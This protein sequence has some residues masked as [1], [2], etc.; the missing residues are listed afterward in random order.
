MIITMIQFDEEKQNKRLEDLKY[1]EEE[2]LVRILAGAK[3]NIPYID[4][5]TTTIENEA[6]RIVPE[7]TARAVEIAPFKL[8]GKNLH[9]A[10]RSPA[11]SELP[12]IMEDLKSQGYTPNLYMASHASLEK[13]WSRFGEISFASVSRAGGLD[14]SGEALLDIASKVHNINDVSKVV[15]DASADNKTHK[16]SHMLEIILG[17]AIAIKA[18]DI[19]IEPGEHEVQVRFRLDGVLQNILT[20]PPETYKL[21]NSRIK[22]ISGL[23]LVIKSI[24]QDGRFSIYESDGTEISMRVSIIPGA[25][26][27][28]IVMRILDPKSIQVK[29]EEIG[30]PKKLLAIMEAEIAKPN[31]LILITGPTG[32]GKTTTL[33]AFLRRIYSPEIKIITIEDPIEYHLAGITQTQVEKN[34]TFLE[35]LRSA[36]RQ[37]PDVIMIG[38]IRDSETAKIA[39]ES[40]LTG[41]LVFS[42]LHTNNA[43]GVIPRLIDLEVNPKILVSALRLSVAQRLVRKLCSECKAEDIVSSEDEALIR[44]ILTGINTENKKV[45][46]F[47]IDPNQPIKTWKAVGCDKCNKTGY[48]GRI[49]IFEAIQTDEAIEKIIPENP[50][51][52]EI[53]RVAHTQGTLDMKEDGIIKILTGITSLSEVRSVVELDEE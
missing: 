20:F 15:A 46:E 53:K 27:E 28:S 37:D 38:E 50:S 52:R 21:V 26:G 13:A 43:G 41:H 3:Y 49:G 5:S 30:I 1:Q 8:L 47:N 44:K 18:S 2:D 16:L 32:S 23:K 11:R 42:T 35:G 6:L 45:E 48:K 25:Y 36:L 10:V 33:Y 19:H 14:I 51:E 34:Y 29:L 17:G 12:Q 7:K 4:L 9:I 31:G 24:A 39:V 22:L 40:A